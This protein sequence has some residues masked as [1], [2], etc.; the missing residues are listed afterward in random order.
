MLNLSYATRDMLSVKYGVQCEMLYFSSGEAAEEH[1][2]SFARLTLMNLYHTA[3]KLTE[4]LSELNVNI[5][6]FALKS[7]DALTDALK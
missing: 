2:A 6:L 5:Q 7:A 3:E 1:A 4:T